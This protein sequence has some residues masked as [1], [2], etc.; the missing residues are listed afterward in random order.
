MVFATDVPLAVVN[1]FST[2]GIMVFATDK[3][4]ST[5]AN[6]RVTLLKLKSFSNHICQEAKKYELS[7]V[8]TG[9]SK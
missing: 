3:M 6:K 5:V 7:S 9:A 1:V 2:N 4:E 8:Y